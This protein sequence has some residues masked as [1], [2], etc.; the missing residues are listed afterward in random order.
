MARVSRR[1]CCSEERSSAGAACGAGTAVAAGALADAVAGGAAAVGA[2][3]TAAGG[4]GGATAGVGGRA[5]A[6]GGLPGICAVAAAWLPPALRVVAGLGVVGLEG[7][8]VEPGAGV[9]AGDAG[10]WLPLLVELT[11]EGASD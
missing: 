8:D 6:A 3:G 10:G 4:T 7:C 9:A 1:R 2:A 11:G 5:P